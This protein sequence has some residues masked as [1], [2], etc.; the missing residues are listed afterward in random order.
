MYG[1]VRVLMILW[2]IGCLAFAGLT[3]ATLSNA[4][5][6]SQTRPERIAEHKE[7]F[8]EATR[9]E[10]ENWADVG[11]AGEAVGLGCCAVGGLGVPL[12]AWVAGMLPL[13][14]LAFVLKPKQVVVVEDR[15]RGRSR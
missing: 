14:I 4:T 8:P 3:M 13:G 1:F 12:F 6:Q 15:R 11:E 7:M 2:T 5:E 10:A 9:E